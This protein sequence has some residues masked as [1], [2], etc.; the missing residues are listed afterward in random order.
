MKNKKN[1]W[2]NKDSLD[3]VYKNNKCLRITLN[4]EQ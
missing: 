2:S 4:D 1:E 3:I